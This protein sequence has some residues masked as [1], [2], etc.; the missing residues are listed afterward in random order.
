MARFTLKSRTR[1]E[2]DFSV[3][4]DGGYVTVYSKALGWD[5]K[6]P[7]DGGGFMGSTLRS[8]G[9]G[10]ER[11]ARRWWKQFLASRRRT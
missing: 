1:G 3:R 6:Q 11:S 10:I 8:D 7:C 9:S 2:I 5:H 4:D